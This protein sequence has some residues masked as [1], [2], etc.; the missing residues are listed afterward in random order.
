M[1]RIEA[2]SESVVTSKDTIVA[3]E[4]F[5]LMR[6]SRYRAD[7]TVPGFIYCPAYNAGG[8]NMIGFGPAREL[9][10]RGYPVLCG[11]F[12][13]VPS[14]LAA[15]DGAHKWG[16][17]ASQTIL[18]T[19]RT[20]LQ[21]TVGAKTGKIGLLYGSGGCALAYAWAKAH[22]TAVYC[23]AGAI[24]TCDV[25]YERAANILGTMQASIETAY[26]NNA[27]WQ[28]A[29]ATHN[30]V[31]VAPNLAAIPQ[32]DYYSTTDNVADDGAGTRHAAFAAAAGAAM[33]QVSLGAIGHST[34][35]LL[36]RSSSETDAFCDWV[37][38][39]LA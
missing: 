10:R 13:C 21:G 1:G 17:D 9:A 29:R 14:A 8:V 30:P 2:H 37:E 34:G 20:Y 11:D 22:P 28:A 33:T 35:N 12:G 27:G 39:H 23:I 16:N 18:D 15:G 4:F 38:A 6:N 5:T 7:G 32:L 26:T 3:G 36:S 25:E 31:E 24:G 19:Y